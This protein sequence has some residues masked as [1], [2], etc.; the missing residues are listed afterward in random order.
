M[1]KIVD[2]SH[3][4]LSFSFLLK[5]SRKMKKIDDPYEPMCYNLNNY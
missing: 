4:P 5:N 1:K 3:R 2:Q